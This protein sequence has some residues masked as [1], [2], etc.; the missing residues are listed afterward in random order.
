M[1]FIKMKNKILNK[2]F[3]TLITL[4]SIISCQ[5]RDLIT[6]ENSTSPIIIDL[7]SESLL[8]DKNFPNN[9]VLTI[10]WSSADYTIPTQV[11]YKVEVSAD[12]AF[13][14]PILLGTVLESARTVTY[15]TSQIN[16]VAGN[17][18]FAPFISSRM[19]LRVSSYL[20][21]ESIIVKSNVTSINVTPY[22]LEYPDF[23][24]VGEA[25]YVGWTA[26]N[27]QILYK[28]ENLSYIYTYLEK[29]KNFRFLGQPD[30]NPTNYSIDESGT[31]AANR[32]FKEYSS[33]ITLGDHEN[34]KFTGETGIYKIVINAKEEIKSLTA[35]SSPISGFD[36]PEIYLVG[37]IAGNGWNEA[38]PITMTTVGGGVYEYTTTLPADA[39]FKVIGQKSWGVLDWGNISGDGD[40]GFLGPKGDN[41]NINFAGSGASYKITVNLKAG[42]YKITPQ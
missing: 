18:G 17:L 39:S 4:L 25:S 12:E 29:D 5:D 21:S 16:T 1:K 20:G 9:P 13:T 34:M 36:F 24:L 35:T 6:V 23:Y 26:S 15:T 42:T 14:K 28:S 7:S 40:T 27:A 19:Y 10:S 37:N 22:V 3:L 31:D 30:W 11:N 8:L 33:N 38:N 41:G 32:Y 2:I